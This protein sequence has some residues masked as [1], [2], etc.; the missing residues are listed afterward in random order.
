MRRSYGWAALLLAGVALVGCTPAAAAPEVAWENGPPTGELEQDPWVAAVRAS[1]LALNTAW[2]TRD[3]TTDDV[4]STTISA[5]I[6]LFASSQINRAEGG[7]FATPPGPTPMIPLSVDEESETQA[8][9]KV[10]K[11]TNWYLDAEQPSVPSTLDG[12][13]F[14]HRVV[15]DGDDRR[16]GAGAP[17]AEECDLSEASIGLFD[18]QPDPDE[19]YSPDDVKVP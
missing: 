7:R 15:R 1:D 8:V 6:D 12:E 19:T 4:R 18:P 2:V 14:E 16:V 3:Y 17:T 5:D 13:V 9:V 11:A 10:C